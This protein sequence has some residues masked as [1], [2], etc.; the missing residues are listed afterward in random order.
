MKDRCLKQPFGK[1]AQ[2][3]LRADVSVIRKNYQ[4]FFVPLK[5]QPGRVEPQNSYDSLMRFSPTSQER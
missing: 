3:R 2:L 4:G 5:D 1:Q